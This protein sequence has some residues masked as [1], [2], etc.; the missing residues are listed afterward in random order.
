MEVNNERGWIASIGF[1]PGILFG[2]RSYVE[3]EYTT[4]VFYLPF[5]DLAIEMDN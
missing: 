3:E 5:V 2:M 1:Y 4:Y